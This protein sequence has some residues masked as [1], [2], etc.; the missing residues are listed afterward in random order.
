VK[1]LPAKVSKGLTVGSRLRV[2]D[3]SG[4]KVVEIISV[5]TVKTVKRRRA[6]AGIGDL[7]TCTVKQGTPEMKHKLVQCVIIRQKK[8][9]KRRDG[10]R[11]KFHDNAAVV[12]KD[13][14][15]GL[16]K[17]TRM[18]GAM[19]KEVLIRYPKLSKLGGI[20]V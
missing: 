13:V 3:N 5:K 10:T 6:S 2:V 4:A 1:A 18:K 15:E 14:K 20:I 8:P 19:P 11:I 7:V 16:P 9:F 12:I 17:G